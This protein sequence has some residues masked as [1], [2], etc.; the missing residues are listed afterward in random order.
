VKLQLKTKQ[1]V[2]KLAFL[3]RGAVVELFS[4]NS[5]LWDL[6]HLEVTELEERVEQE[7]QD[8]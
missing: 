5:S 6:C 1:S 2:M 4:L 7:G 8:V 3:D